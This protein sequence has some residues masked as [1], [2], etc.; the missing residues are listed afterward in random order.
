M[1]PAIDVSDALTRY[2]GVE[3]GRADTRMSEQFLNDAQV[4]PSLEQMGRE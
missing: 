1:G 4:G 2:V 3:L